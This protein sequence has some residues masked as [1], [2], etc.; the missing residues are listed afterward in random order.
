[1]RE[2]Q[3]PLCAYDLSVKIH[4][5]YGSQIKDRIKME[6]LGIMGSPR[7]GGNTDILLDHSLKGAKDAGAKVEKI[8]LVDLKI[9]PCLEIYA[10]LKGGECAIKDDMRELYKKLIQCNRLIIGAPIFFYGVSATTKAFIDRC[11]ALWV[12]KNILKIPFPCAGDRK[13]AFISVGATRGKRLFEG[14]VLMMKYFFEAIDMS[15]AGELLVRGIDKK[16]E[17]LEH[18]DELDKAYELGR[19][20]AQK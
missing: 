15:Y 18:R 2:E 4:K 10:C 11:Q 16:G 3:I 5:K 9:L 6:F 17:I 1:M 13:G 8:Y 19:S 20:L 7:K 12:R 14:S